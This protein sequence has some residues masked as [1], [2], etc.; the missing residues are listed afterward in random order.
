VF[1]LGDAVPVLPEPVLDP[2]Q[3]V[4]DV[5]PEV[6]P[7]RVTRRAPD[8]RLVPREPLAGRVDDE[9]ADVVAFLCSPAESFVDGAVVPARGVSRLERVYGAREL[10]DP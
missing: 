7:A 1:P 5:V 3:A 10:D 6:R 8:R 9:I 4:Q 2:E